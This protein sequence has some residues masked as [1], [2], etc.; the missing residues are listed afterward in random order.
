MSLAIVGVVVLILTIVAYA[1]SHNTDSEVDLHDPKVF[2]ER[3]D[4]YRKQRDGFRSNSRAMEELREWKDRNDEYEYVE[5]YVPI[6]P[7]R[8]I[9]P[10]C[11]ELHNASKGALN[12][13]LEV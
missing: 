12:S 6:Y 2:Q 1:M 5:L 9:L 10:D 8:R 11:L 7:W 3:K 13:N 4:L